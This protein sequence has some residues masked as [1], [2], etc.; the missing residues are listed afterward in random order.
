MARHPQDGVL[1]L[2]TTPREEGRDGLKDR[3]SAPLHRPHDWTARVRSRTHRVE[4]HDTE[5]ATR[6]IDYRLGHLFAG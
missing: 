5:Q 3:S 4:A 6:I 2:E 1:P